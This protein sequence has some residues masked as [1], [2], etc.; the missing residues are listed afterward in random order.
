MMAE[1]DPLVGF[2]VIFAVIVD[3]A[4][5]GAALIQH[6]HAGRNPLGVKTKTNSV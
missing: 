4:W 3:L 2:D 6:E 5:C 1:D